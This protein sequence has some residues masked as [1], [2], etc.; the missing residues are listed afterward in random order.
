MTPAQPW[1]SRSCWLRQTQN[2]LPSGSRMTTQPAPSGRRRSSA[3]V[4]PMPASRSTSSSR[5]LPSMPL[6]S[7]C[8]RF[9][10][11]LPSGT[12][13]K[14]RNGSRSVRSMISSSPGSSSS[15][16]GRPV[17]LLHQLAISYGLSAST[18][19]A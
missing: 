1:A 6:T 9:L 8:T 16:S 15:P 17:A 7:K 12:F 13:R 11:V 19:M 5:V 10:T 3:M 18:E 4:A 2:S 14:S